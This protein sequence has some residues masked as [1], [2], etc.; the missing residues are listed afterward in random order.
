MQS[1]P[2]GAEGSGAAS[3]DPWSW[4]PSELVQ[5]GLRVSSD[6]D[7][8]SP[9]GQDLRSGRPPPAPS[10]PRLALVCCCSACPDLGLPQPIHLLQAALSAVQWEEDPEARPCWVLA[11]RASLPM[12]HLPVHGHCAPGP[13][14]Q[15]STLSPG[16]SS[17]GQHSH[18]SVCFFKNCTLI[19]GEQPLIRAT[20]QM[21]G[22]WV[23][24]STGRLAGASCQCSCSTDWGAGLRAPGQ[25]RGCGRRS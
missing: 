9:A 11:A 20:Y 3:V 14:H 1:C 17:H 10:T 12:G 4:A 5:G 8:P 15:R 16:V 7:P 2:W 22:D 21:T 23:A 6:S 13:G 25:G 24:L 19:V 18:W